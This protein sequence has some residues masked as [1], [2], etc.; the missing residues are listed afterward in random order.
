MNRDRITWM[1]CL[2]YK[3]IILGNSIRFYI[4]FWIVCVSSAAAEV[5]SGEFENIS[6]VDSNYQMP[7]LSEMREYNLSWLREWWYVRAEIERNKES[8]VADRTVVRCAPEYTTR[9]WNAPGRLLRLLQST[10]RV[11]DQCV[12][13][14]SSGCSGNCQSGGQSLNSMINLTIAVHGPRMWQYVE[15]WI[16][17]CGRWRNTVKGI[18]LVVHLFLHSI[19]WFSLTRL[20]SIVKRV[21]IFDWSFDVATCSLSNIQYHLPSPPIDL[22]LA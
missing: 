3:S 15:Q 14:A 21:C 20:N 19:G 13:L 6:G 22:N 10:L 17:C 18:S 16:F 2:G 12:C 8:R 1:H 4:E 11:K 7:N 9:S 5:K